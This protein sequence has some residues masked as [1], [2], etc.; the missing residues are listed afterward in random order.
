M[1]NLTLHLQTDEGL[2]PANLMGS[3]QKEL[4]SLPVVQ[5]ANL[6]AE[7][8][9]SIGPAEIIAGIS[10]ATV[11]IKSASEAVQ[12]ITKF[13]TAVQEL[14]KAG[15][16]LREAVVDVGMRRV[17]VA[18]LTQADIEKLAA[19]LTGKAAS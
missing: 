14:V 4:E 8:Y 17:P 19:N 18:E 6:N 10:F 9:R 5:S 11:A 16:G 12:A 15:K 1:A 13:V 7:H 2:D 3:I